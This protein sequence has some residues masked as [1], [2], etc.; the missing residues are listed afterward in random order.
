VR[1]DRKFS[2]KIEIEYYPRGEGPDGIGEMIYGGE[3]DEDKL[4]K[5]MDGKMEATA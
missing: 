2:D 3:F 4:K 5:L 1:P